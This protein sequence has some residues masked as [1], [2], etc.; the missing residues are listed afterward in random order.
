MTRTS[1][2]NIIN[3]QNGYT[4][5]KPS[6]AIALRPATPIPNQRASSLPAK[7]ANVASSCRQPST[8]MIQPHVLRSLKTYVLL[9]PNTFDREIARIP[10]MKFHVP[11]SPS[12]MPAK[13][14]QPMPRTSSYS[15]AP[16]PLST[17]YAPVAIDRPPPVTIDT[18]RSRRPSKEIAV[19]ARRHPPVG[20]TAGRRLSC[21]GRARRLGPD[22]PEL[23]CTLDRFAPRRDVE[24]AV[25]GDGLRLHRVPGDLE[26]LG[27]LPEGEVAREKREEACL[28]GC[29][30]GGPAVVGRPSRVEAPAE[31]VGAR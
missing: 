15:S 19:T 21:S 25:H 24:L 7:M 9:T 17:S 18:R 2:V 4:G 1:T 16:T 13:A 27:D 31:L 30:R 20:M 5:T 14:I 12:M 26:S 28:G 29:K 23:A 6:C 8:S 11:A 22:E 10:S 3:A